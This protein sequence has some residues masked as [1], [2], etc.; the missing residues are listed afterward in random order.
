MQSN[1]NYKY[2]HPRTK[3]GSKPDII[4]RISKEFGWVG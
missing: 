3:D 1:L 4:V 2:D